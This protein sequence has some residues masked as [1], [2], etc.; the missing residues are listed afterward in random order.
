[1]NKIG[2]AYTE[3]YI[4]HREYVF[5]KCWY[6]SDKQLVLTD[7]VCNAIEVHA[8]QP[9]FNEFETARLWRVSG[10]IKPWHV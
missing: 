10:V 3:N 9:I 1:M 2:E 5:L 7:E 6:R 8:K 4:G